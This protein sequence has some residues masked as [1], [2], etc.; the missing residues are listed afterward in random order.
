MPPI[1]CGRQTI[2]VRLLQTITNDQI[3][4]GTIKKQMIALEIL[5][6]SNSLAFVL[7]STVK[8]PE[9]TKCQ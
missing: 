5:Y 9:V 4:L 1:K 7:R 8:A 2:T 3:I 6:R